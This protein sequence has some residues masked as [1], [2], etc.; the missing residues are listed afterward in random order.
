TSHNDLGGLLS[1]TGRLKEA[2]AAFL[3]ALVLQKQLVADFPARPDFHIE[4]A[5][6]LS[7]LGDLANNRR[8]YAE[9]C[10]WLDEALRH[11]QVA[12]QSNS[13]HPFYREVLRENR[14]GMAEARLGLGEHA[15]A[16]AA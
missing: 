2:E 14:K 8:E 12:L 10:R 5:V 15:A 7:N 3:D 11:N 16:A 1:G 13:H 4:L 6:T 9:A